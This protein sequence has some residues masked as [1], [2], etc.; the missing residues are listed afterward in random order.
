M[1]PAI[2]SLMF[3]CTLPKEGRFSNISYQAHIEIHYTSTKAI[4]FMR[5]FRLLYSNFFY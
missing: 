4:N 1:S 5:V 3:V 2:C